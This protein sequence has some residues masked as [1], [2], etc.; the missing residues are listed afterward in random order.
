MANNISSV[1]QTLLT[2]AEWAHIAPGKVVVAT[3][4]RAWV[5]EPRSADD[6]LCQSNGGVLVVL[7]LLAKLLDTA[8]AAA[9]H[10][11]KV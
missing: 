4:E 10:T 7:P 8:I 5:Y 3:N 6:R 1:E 2:N 9:K 11:V